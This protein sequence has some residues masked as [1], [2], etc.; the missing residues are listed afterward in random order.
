MPQPTRTLPTPIP[1]SPGAQAFLNAVGALAQKYNVKTLVITLIDPGDGRQK[2][3]GA[4]Q[5]LNDLRDVT[6]EKFG[7]FDG[8]DTGWG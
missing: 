6:A 1:P 4:P 8:G 3:F 7:L 5:A 2:L